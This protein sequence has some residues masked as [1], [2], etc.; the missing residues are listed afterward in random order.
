MLFNSI[1]KSTTSA[2]LKKCD[3]FTPNFVR[4]SQ[5]FKGSVSNAFYVCI[6]KLKKGYCLLTF[7]I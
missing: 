3:R 1:A 5:I 4:L 6:I 2:A 7:K